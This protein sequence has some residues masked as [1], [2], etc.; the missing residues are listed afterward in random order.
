MKRQEA[1]SLGKTKNSQ[2]NLESTI[3][4]STKRE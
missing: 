3:S 2:K 1:F 4:R